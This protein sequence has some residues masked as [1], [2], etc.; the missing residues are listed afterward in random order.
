MVNNNFVQPSQRSY[1]GAELPKQETPQKQRVLVVDDEDKV[2]RFICMLLNRSGYETHSCRSAAEARVLIAGQPWNLVL[3]D[4]VMPKE[5]GFELV[6]WVGEH[7]P[8]LPIMVMTA[9]TS[10]SI[11]NQSLKLGVASVLHKPFTI[12]GL[13]QAV[14]DIIQLNSP[15]TGA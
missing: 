9:H 11:Q 12:E 2:G 10:D 7:H 6:R 14:A 5:N 3:T 15:D 13:R 8:T 1:S 4:V